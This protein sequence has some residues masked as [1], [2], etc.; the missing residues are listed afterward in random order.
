MGGLLGSLLG[1]GA[2]STGSSGSGLG[3][4]GSLLGSLMG[5]GQVDTDSGAVDSGG[6]N[7][8]SGLVQ[9]IIGFVLGKLLTG[10]SAGRGPVMRSAA[11]GEGLDLDALAAQLNTEQGVD[12]E[13]LRSTGMPQE[14]AAKTGLDTDTAIKALQKVLAMLLGQQKKQTAK[15]PAKKKPKSTAKTAKQSAAKK[16]KSTAKTSKSG[17]KTSP[18]RKTSSRAEGIDIEEASS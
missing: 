17:K 10:K 1:G 15:K 6:L 8:P 13:Y 9:Q 7:L 2:G 18:R 16:P 3:S 5:G 14:L 4:M 12:Q 11:M